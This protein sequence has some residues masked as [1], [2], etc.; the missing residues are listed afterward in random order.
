MPNCCRSA[1]AHR[2]PPIRPT[3]SVGGIRLF[4]K[5]LPVCARR[6]LSGAFFFYYIPCR[7]KSVTEQDISLII[8][9]YRFDP[10]GIL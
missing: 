10:I 8:Y 3:E 1:Q 7:D 2:L 4:G 5:G 6:R 9:K